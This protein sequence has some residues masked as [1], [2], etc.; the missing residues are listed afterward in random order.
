MR[1]KVKA[2]LTRIIF[3]QSLCA[4]R[5]ESICGPAER[6]ITQTSP[7]SPHLMVRSEDLWNDELFLIRVIYGYPKFIKQ[8]FND[9]WLPVWMQQSGYQTYYVGK[10]MNAFDPSNYNSSY[11][12]GFNGSDF[13]YGAGE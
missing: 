3:V 12:N 13:L 1:R 7:T 6:R 2:R 4:A 9:D 10:L 11:A 8:G 5:R